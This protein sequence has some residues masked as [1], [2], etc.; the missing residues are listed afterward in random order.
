MRYSSLSEIINFNSAGS[1]K[2]IIN[3]QGTICCI[4]H[5]GLPPKDYFKTFIWFHEVI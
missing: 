3:K 4:Y 5:F 2:Y 1:C